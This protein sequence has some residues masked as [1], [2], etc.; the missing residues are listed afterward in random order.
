MPPDRP[1]GSTACG[2]SS[3]ITWNFKARTPVRAFFVP[4]VKPDSA[5]ER[6]TI[7]R[8]GQR[9]APTCQLTQI[10]KSGRKELGDGPPHALVFVPRLLRR[11]DSA[12]RRPYQPR[13]SGLSRR[14]QLAQI[15]KS[16][17]AT[18]VTVAPGWLKAV[19]AHQ[20]EAFQLKTWRRK[21]LIGPLVKLPENVH[22]ALTTG[23]GTSPAQFLKRDKALGAVVPL[24][25]RKTDKLTVLEWRS[26]TL[27]AGSL[28]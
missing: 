14:R 15:F 2:H 1:R 11:G 12:A 26:A 23:T 27:D 4:V 21:R 7:E 13:S 10:A 24:H 9:G 22:L 16:K 19:T 6:W 17:D 25:H 5:V 8:Q 28:G 3:Q 20:H 18:A